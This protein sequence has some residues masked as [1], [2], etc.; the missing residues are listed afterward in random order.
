MEKVFEW[1]ER[2]AGMTVVWAAGDERPLDEVLKSFAEGVYVQARRTGSFYV[3]QS[4]NLRRRQKEHL[5]RGVEIIGLAVESMPGAGEAQLQA[6]E[7]EVISLLRS[8]RAPL[9][10]D[11]KVQEVRR[12]RSEADLASLWGDEL[13]VAAVDE[14]F[15]SA[16]SVSS[17]YCRR[18]ERMAETDDK[19]RK[20]MKAFA[21]HPFG[22]RIIHLVDEWVRSLVPQAGA[23]YGKRWR[24]E[25]EPD[26]P[27]GSAWIT[28]RFGREAGLVLTRY[29]DRGEYLCG[30][31]R[32]A[33]G[34]LIEAWGTLEEAVS[35]LGGG[36]WRR[37][38]GGDWVGELARC[39]RRCPEK[40]AACLTA[41]GRHW[42][43][44]GG[45]VSVQGS[46]D[47]VSGLLDREQTRL[48]LQLQAVRDL[49]TGRC[50]PT[51][52]VTWWPW[53]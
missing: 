14:F 8:L 5:A 6:R 19:D 48:S 11:A 39:A 3:G 50:V 9:A 38:E 40:K 2:E 24:V 26:A 34:P 51:A 1:L 18:A 30:G 37:E 49:L 45:T 28:V 44:G 52:A 53:F 15:A 31:V 36:P 32:L 29:W 33:Q 13:S 16:W 25:F 20:A 43:Q 23:L 12:R 17:P 42:T 35:V 21:R 47:W 4:G 27:Y 22:Y 41:A 10:N 46:I 7:T